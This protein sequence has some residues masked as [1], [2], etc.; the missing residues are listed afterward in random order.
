MTLLPLGCRFDVF[1]LR[2]ELIT[3]A[4]GASTGPAAIALRQ[5]SPRARAWCRRTARRPSA[6]R[7][8][9][10]CTSDISIASSSDLRTFSMPKRS[11]SS[12]PSLRRIHRAPARQHHAEHLARDVGARFDD[13]VAHHQHVV[14]RHAAM[15]LGPFAADLLGIGHDRLEARI[16]AVGDDRGVELA[17]D[18]HLHEL[19]AG[20]RAARRTAGPCIRRCGRPRRSPSSPSRRPCRRARPACRAPTCRWSAYRRARRRACRAARSAS[21]RRARN[22]RAGCGSGRA[23]RWWRAAGCRA[24]CSTWPAGTC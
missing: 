20:R 11:G 2:T 16:A 21:A 23:P 7:T 13:R 9:N 22:C 1:L 3:P 19:L 10:F 15:G 24:C 12:L 17:V 14:D 6:R 8:M 5:I 4:R 18:Q